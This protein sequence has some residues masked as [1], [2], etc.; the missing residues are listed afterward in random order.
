[1]DRTLKTILS[2]FLAEAGWQPA[3]TKP[4]AGA[5]L[6]PLLWFIR[7]VMKR[8][9]AKA[10]GNTDTTRDYEYLDWQDLRRFTEEF[11]RLVARRATASAP[12][13]VTA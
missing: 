9:A 3:I 11:G 4:V 2:R 5:L 13:I 6:H 7:R 10:G 8:I 12:E 1:M